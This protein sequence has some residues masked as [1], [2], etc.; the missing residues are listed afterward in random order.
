MGFIPWSEEHIGYLRSN[1]RQLTPAE[2]ADDLGR[3]RLEVQG[4]MGR[5]G[6]AI[7]SE[8]SQRRTKLGAAKRQARE[9][10]ERAQLREAQGLP[11]PKGPSLSVPE[12]FWPMISRRT[13]RPRKEP[14][15]IGPVRGVPLAEVGPGCCHFVVTPIGFP[16][17][18][19]NAPK[20]AGLRLPYCEDH[21]NFV[22]IKWEEK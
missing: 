7:G 9:R 22:Y 13:G 19:C 11:A 6:L 17:R 14:K 10:A 1:Y 21:Y 8:E 16:S 18:H 20:K 3:T 5:L 12:N 2:L 15:F 4:K